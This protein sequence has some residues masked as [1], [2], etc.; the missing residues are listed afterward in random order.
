M[1]WTSPQQLLHDIVDLGQIFVAQSWGNSRYSQWVGVSGICPQIRSVVFPTKACPFL[2]DAT[3]TLLPWLHIQPEV[4]NSQPAPI[5]MGPPPAAPSY[6]RCRK[7]VFCGM[8]PLLCWPWRSRWSFTQ[9]P[10]AHSM[11][12][13]RPPAVSTTWFSLALPAGLGMRQEAEHKPTLTVPRLPN[14]QATAC[15]IFC[16][17]A[18]VGAPAVQTPSL[19][20]V[21]SSC[22]VLWAWVIELC[23]HT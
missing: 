2:P 3:P 5:I 15:V 6:G 9:C 17:S 20:R 8:S 7:T 11:P 1:D 22:I 23:S 21:A 19:P 4:T 12:C 16:F 13:S 18:P 10:G 14:W